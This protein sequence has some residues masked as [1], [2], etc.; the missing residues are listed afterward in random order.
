VGVWVVD[1]NTTIRARDVIIDS[2]MDEAVGCRHFCR[3]HWV[4]PVR[5]RLQ[6]HVVVRLE[7]V[8]LPRFDDLVIQS[9][10][11]ICHR[12]LQAIF[13]VYYPKEFAARVRSFVVLSCCSTIVDVYFLEASDTDD[14]PVVTHVEESIVG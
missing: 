14:V 8:L 4:I 10:R 11:P 5:E 3:Y 12:L 1:S 2:E 9:M 7:T 13:Q 6:S